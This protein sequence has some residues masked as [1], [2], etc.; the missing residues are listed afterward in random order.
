[1]WPATAS[2][3]GA[4][5]SWLQSSPAAAGNPGGPSGA[6]G[7]CICPVFILA[8]DTLEHVCRCMSKPR[9]ER[10]LA[11]QLSHLQRGKCQYQRAECEIIDIY[12]YN[13]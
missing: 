3:W 4:A 8:R 2:P 5:C 9:C 10:S 7:P 12:I 1:M 13:K 11:R 6:R